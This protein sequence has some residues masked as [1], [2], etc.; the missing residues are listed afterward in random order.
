MLKINCHLLA[1]H[2]LKNFISFLSSLLSGVS[3]LPHKGIYCAW[4]I[5]WNLRIIYHIIWIILAKFTLLKNITFTSVDELK[6]H[7]LID[8]SSAGCKSFLLGYLQVLRGHFIV[9]RSPKQRFV[10]CILLSCLAFPKYVFHEYVLETSA[11]KFWFLW[12]REDHRIVECIS[13]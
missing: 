13:L 4:K 7:D 3:H 5:I 12:I 9:I 10:L 1:D 2:H 11:W 6:L 8:S